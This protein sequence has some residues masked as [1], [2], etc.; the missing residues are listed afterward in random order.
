MKTALFHYC[1]VCD[2]AGAMVDAISS[3]K[4]CTPRKKKGDALC[5]QRL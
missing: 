1:L 2:H 3:R 5:C 4:L